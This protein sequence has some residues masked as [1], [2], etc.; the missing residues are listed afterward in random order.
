MEHDY[1][2]ELAVAKSIARQAGALMLRYFDGDDKQTE[3]KRDNSPVTI[4]DKEINRL[5]IDEL[6]KH[7]SDGIIGEEEST[8]EY[9]TGR[10]WICDPIDGT[11]GYV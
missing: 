2:T 3:R 9:G 4:A 6:Q 1:S 10:R 5:V 7:F 11:K 8:A